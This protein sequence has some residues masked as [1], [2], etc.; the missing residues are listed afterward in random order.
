MKDMKDMKSTSSRKTTFAFFMFFM[1]FMV[2]CSFR[3]ALTQQKPPVFRAKTDLMQLDVTVLDKQGVPVRG[4]TKDDFVLLEDNKPQTVEGFTAVD[5]ED[6]KKDVGPVWQHAAS[7][8]VVS[9]EIDNH[10]IFILV[11]DDARS[12][13]LKEEPPRTPDLWAVK[14]MKESVALF[15]SQLNPSDLVALVFTQRTRLSQNL[16]SDH[17]R[18]VKA[19]QAFPDGGAGDLVTGCLGARNAVGTMKG[20]VNLLAALP[21][22]RKALVYFGGEMPIIPMSPD[23]CGI[24]WDWRDLFSAAQQAHVT[25]SPVDTMGLR[26]KGMKDQYLTVAEN[27]GGSA[28]VNSNDF[29][30]GIR[31]IFVQNSSYYL[32][33]YQPTHAQDDGTFRRITVTVK[34]RPDVEVATR[35]NYWAPRAPKPGDP[36][37]PP[38]P[39][40]VDALAGLLPVSKLALRVTAAP[41]AVPESASAI[42]TIALGV[43][44][45]AFANRENEQIELLVKAF[46]ADGDE[47][48]SDTQTIPITVPA[49]RADSNITRYEV[50]AR[51]DLPKPGKYEV[52]LSAHSNAADTRGS[53]YV[54]VDV[55]DYRKEKLSLSGVVLNSA[56]PAGPVAPAR[57]LR[58]ILPVTPTSERTFATSDIVTAF[59]RVYQGGSDKIAPVT[60]K[61]TIVDGAGKSVATQ[62]D[63]IAAD[64][65]SSDRASD[66][67]F[68]LPL[69]TL[70]PGEY[71]LTFEASAGKF[72]AR[73]DVRFQKQ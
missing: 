53:V 22:R 47:R 23:E 42:V 68:R 71:L 26:T 66:F 59:M 67:Q 40:D 7:P 17:A 70:V 14:R 46:T 8:D 15:V 52:R 39:P 72:T 25:V 50:L 24:F 62:S 11:V 57:L 58:E 32:L 38:P 43:K 2:P 36:P 20:I 13:G 6:V 54:D 65:F 48:A 19:V 44:Q 45:P 31:R 51:L 35:R 1:L 37:P 18:L 4:L 21:D 27:T 34:G 60:M 3:A 5:L 41:F 56:L 49:A 29:A 12:M 64:R 73:R 30:P 63:T 9:N 28:I 55:P 69:T 10:R 61:V 33:A 16:T